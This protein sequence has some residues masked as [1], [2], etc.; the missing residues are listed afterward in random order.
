MSRTAR[1]WTV[2]AANLALVVA[3]VV[4]G[5]LANSLGVLAEG[6][7]YIADAAAIGVSLL[8]IHLSER[9]PSPRRPIGFPRA[10]RIAAGIN[11]GWLLTLSFVVA[12]GALYRLITGVHQVRGLPVVVVSGVAAVVMTLGAV[13]L[14]GGL[15]H[16]ADADDN[17][18][19]NLRAVLLDTAADAA[20][21][22]GVALTGAVIYFVHGVYWLDPAVALVI[23]LV[24]GYQ[25]GRLLIRIGSRLRV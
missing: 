9:P 22:V 8:A 3:L 10:T 19:L 1:L 20:A 6:I 25:A 13:V 12:A 7:D 21:A 4:V 11:A 24:V 14:G 15:G 16:S 5:F 23:S 2:L 17:V 18:D